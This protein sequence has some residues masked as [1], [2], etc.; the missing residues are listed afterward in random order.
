MNTAPDRRARSTSVD[1][2][3]VDDEE[4]IRELLELSLMRMGLGCDAAGSV[5]EARALLEKR[6]YRLCLTDMRLPDG[7]GLEL[8]EFIQHHQPG[9]PVAVITAFGSIETAIRALKLG[10]FDFVTKPLALEALR[11]LVIRVMSGG[12]PELGAQNRRHVPIELL[13]KSVNGSL[14]Q[15]HALFFAGRNQR[16]QRAG[17][18]CQIPLGNARLVG[19][20]IAA[21]PVDRGKHR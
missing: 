15:L 9:L 2:L 1:V 3:V 14:R 4:D 6:R 11:Q 16:Q 12:Q 18:L 10:A 17:E 13:C 21:L 5:A 20:G 19:K 7:D 8:V